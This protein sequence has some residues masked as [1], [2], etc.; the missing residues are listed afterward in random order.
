MVADNFQTNPV[1]PAVFLQSFVLYAP[2]IAKKIV[3]P[4]L[5]LLSEKNY[6]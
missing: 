1:I 4:I 3:G 5:L 6:I 2:I